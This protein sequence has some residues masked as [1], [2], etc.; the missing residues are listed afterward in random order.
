M[1]TQTVTGRIPRA[2]SAKRRV[3][4]FTLIELM[5]VVAIV[6][7]LAA[8]AYPAYTKQ[9]IRGQRT[10]GQN[11]VVD[12]A[13][14]EEQYLLDN[15]NYTNSMA[16]LGYAALPAEIQP[17]SGAQLY[18]PPTITIVA[19]A[20]GTPPSY[21]IQLSP[22]PGSNLANHNDG[23]LWVNNIGQ[24]YRSVVGP[25]ETTFN[26]AGAGHDCTFED[27]TCIPH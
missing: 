1:Q 8:V 5:I 4:G 27:G 13:Q 23:T 11:F 20:A 21:N 22:F 17:A 10:S 14:R 16:A 9:I 7:I 6:A 3:A 19:A 26:A 25:T 15:R 24:R 2:P 12:L 18:S